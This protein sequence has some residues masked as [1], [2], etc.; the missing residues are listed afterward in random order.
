MYS[1][2]HFFAKRNYFVIADQYGFFGLMKF[3]AP[4]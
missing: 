3:L 2:G 1:A 4:S